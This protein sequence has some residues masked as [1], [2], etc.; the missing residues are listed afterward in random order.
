MSARKSLSSESVAF[1]SLEF[2][3]P[4][5]NRYD[6]AHVMRIRQNTISFLRGA[7]H[8]RA[9]G[10]LVRG[11]LAPSY[12][13]TLLASRGDPDVLQDALQV[14][15]RID[16]DGFSKIYDKF[17]GTSLAPGFSKYLDASTHVAR[18]VQHA[19]SLG[20]H[21]AAPLRLLDIGS[22]PGY[23]SFACQF[24]GH[25]SKGLDI[26]DNEMYVGLKKLLKV[27]CVV[28]RIEAFQPLPAD[29]LNY[30]I[31]TCFQLLF[32][33]RPDG[34]PWSPRKWS[35]FLRE[36]ASHLNPGGR[37][38]LELN[39]VQEKDR[40]MRA[41]NLRFLRELGAVEQ[42]SVLLLT[43]PYVNSAGSNL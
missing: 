15:S 18:A 12:L 7:L 42:D 5:G 38:I 27:E 19:R 25:A 36:V 33:R 8:F 10:Q 39:T 41:E 17:K 11:S 1:C 14:I 31:I 2:T 32:D 20:L 22:G 43:V 13:Q 24:Y 6:D 16:R 21:R 37:L 34:T 40:A 29:G 9:L 23:F 35:Y 3:R 30:D 26:G 4:G 28:H